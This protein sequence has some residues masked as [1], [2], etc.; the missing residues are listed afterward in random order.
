MGT[1]DCGCGSAAPTKTKDANM[2]LPG[3]Y[4]NCCEDKDISSKANGAAREY[5]I[6]PKRY[7]GLG[8]GA[9]GFKA[10]LRIDQIDTATKVSVLLQWSIDGVNWQSGQSL[11]TD[12]NATGP[13]V[14]ESTVALEQV[15]YLRL[16][17]S[18]AQDSPTSQVDATISVWTYARFT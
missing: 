9:T 10:M 14:G 5:I 17:A 3:I 4:V 1:K 11:I 12:K 16:I 6:T 7:W 2:Q 13:Y 8:L 18:I 15:P